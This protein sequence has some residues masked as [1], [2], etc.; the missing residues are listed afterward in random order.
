MG[1][2]Y[3][4]RDRVVAQNV[5]L[6]RIRPALIGGVRPT[7]AALSPEEVYSPTLQADSAPKSHQLPSAELSP[8]QV[9]SDGH[10]SFHLRL[11]LAQEFRVMASLRHPN[12]VSVLDYGFDDEQMPFFTMEL[13]NDAKTLTTAASGQSLAVKVELVVQ[14]LRALSYLHRRGILHRDVKPANVLVIR[15]GE[16][17]NAKLVDFGLS[18]LRSGRVESDGE[19][20]GTLGYLAPEV[21]RGRPV[22]EQSDLYAV[23]AVAFEL[24][25]GV[26]LFPQK[27]VTELLDA[28]LH[29]E[30]DWARGRLPP[31]LRAVVMRLGASEPAER[32]VSAHAAAVA[33]AKAAELALPPESEAVRESFLQAAELVGREEELGALK[34]ALQAARSGRGSG[35]LI[36]GESGVGKSRLLDEVRTQ[37]LTSGVRVLRGQLGRDDRGGVSAL[38]DALR[39]LCL[40]VEISPLEAGVIKGLVPELPALL[41]RDVSD[42]LTL[43]AQA[44]RLR[45]FSVLTSVL[46]RSHVPTLLI[47][48]DLQWADADVR[49][50]LGRILAQLA[51]RPFLMI[52]TYRTEECPELP[53][54]LP[55]ARPLALKR[56]RN[57]SLAE[58]VRAMLGDEVR[59]DLVQFLQKETEGNTLLLIEAVRALAEQAGSL[60]SAASGPVPAGLFTGG[61]RALLGRR[62]ERLPAKWQPMLRFCA[63]AGRQIDLAVLQDACPDFEYFLRDGADVSVFEVSEQQWRFSHDKLREQ[64]VSQLTP[65]EQRDLHKR[66][67]ERVLRTYADVRPH[68]ATLAWHFV[69]AEESV[70]AARY[71]VI[72]GEDALRQGAVGHAETLLR[73]ALLWQS[74][75]LRGEIPLFAQVQ[76]R[77]LLAG[78]LAGLGRLSECIAEVEAVMD[79]VDI[80]FRHTNARFAGNLASQILSQLTSLRPAGIRHLRSKEMATEVLDAIDVAVAP[81]VMRC[82]SARMLFCS[83]LSIN[84]SELFGLRDRET[85]AAA[86]LGYALYAGQMRSIGNRYIAHATEFVRE[87]HDPRVSEV[88]FMIRACLLQFYGDWTESESYLRRS[89][90]EGQLIGDSTLILL[91]RLQLTSND[92]FRARYENALMEAQFMSQLADQSQNKQYQAWSV[93]TKAVVSCQRGDFAGAHQ[94]LNQALP[95]VEI[96]QDLVAS[97]CCFGLRAL[98]ALRTGKTAEAQYVG[99]RALALLE[100]TTMTGHG[101]MEGVA[102]PV[103]VFF[104]LWQAAQSRA[105]K[106][107]LKRLTRRALRQLRRFSVIFKFAQ[108]RLW[109]WEAIVLRADARTSAA[110]RRLQEACAEA[111]RLMMP[112]DAG[113][114]H[115]ALAQSSAGQTA[116]YHARCAAEAFARI[117]TSRRL[118]SF[119]GAA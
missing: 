14:I 28:A 71:L 96:A 45:L 13:L 86:Y 52:G 67:A 5:A 6:K 95:L 117:G 108:P 2:V 66:V 88:Y 3:R 7:S 31:S 60:A 19:V 72:A 69:R 80:P 34:T 30:P 77:R 107:A 74:R 33:L 9:A 91:S 97:V 98:T 76:T 73:D 27:R 38:A 84:L 18:M 8:V 62:L 10:A 115:Q 49:E 16:S 63:V 21:L 40:E 105:E 114:A 81:L 59:P 65:S 32:Y 26:P 112:F 39:S 44:A 87:N 85:S 50:L 90:S 82:D 110:T 17:L 103:E 111:E 70:L 29:T 47:L 89:I 37:A 78:A 93:L 57:E 92:F 41:G 56:L 83:F 23:G 25:T 119:A 4:V 106:A 118:E 75:C 36:G 55:A 68:A 53:K 35:Y 22:T 20:S 1:I 42:S 99:E 48:E 46:L 24:F 102:A 61:M 94:T 100:G 113:L 104:S 12:I 51:E 116:Q 15:S 109:L 101:M 58:L 54:E 11:L 64:V 43:N 79:L